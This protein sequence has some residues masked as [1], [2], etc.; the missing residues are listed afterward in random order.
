MIDL[1]KH[2]FDEDGLFG[3]LL[4]LGSS[5]FFLCGLLL[6]GTFSFI[7]IHEAVNQCHVQE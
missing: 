6:I 1:I 3:P 7:T 2:I 5:T 4:L